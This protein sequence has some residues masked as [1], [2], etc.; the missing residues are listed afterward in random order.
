[1]ENKRIFFN[2]LNNFIHPDFDCGDLSKV[3]TEDWINILHISQEQA[4]FPIIFDKAWNQD[5]YMELSDENKKS[6]KLKARNSVI[7]QSLKTDYFL[8]VYRQF[9]QQNINP[10]VVKGLILRNIYQKPDYR[11]SSDEDILVS[12]N[13]FYMVDKILQYNGYM[14]NNI[15]KPLKEHEIS[16]FNAKRGSYIELHLSLFPETSDAYG[17]LNKQFKDVFIRSVSEKINGTEVYTLCPTQHMLYLVCHSMKH[18]MHCGF[19]ARQLMDIINFAETYGDVIDWSEVIR[20]AKN[21][22]MY[23]FLMNLFAGG[24]KYLGFSWRKA[25][26]KKPDIKLEPENLITDMMEGGVFGQNDEARLHSANITLQSV[27]PKKSK[28]VSKNILFPDI[29]YMQ[30]K[31]PYLK[32]YKCML[33]FAWMQRIFSYGISMR[34]KGIE[35]A[36]DIGKKRVELLKQYKII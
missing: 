20:R 35:R 23:V 9:T 24:E 3:T 2:I 10:L 8:S 22:N 12:K 13:D 29:N 32:K 6:F 4:V 15:E 19:G 27:N 28:S 31:Y 33:L 5:G 25:G 30:D 14:R 36:I 26:I 7:A 34:R 11:M 16:Y 1:M 21:E 18:F 17:H